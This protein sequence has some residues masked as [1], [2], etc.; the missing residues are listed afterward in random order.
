MHG[1]N[2]ASRHFEAV[3]E[4][5]TISLTGVALK[6]ASCQNSAI[7]VLER[8]KKRHGCGNAPRKEREFV[9]EARRT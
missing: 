5:E 8:E 7:G 3:R 2:L 4:K 9:E 6:N 1:H